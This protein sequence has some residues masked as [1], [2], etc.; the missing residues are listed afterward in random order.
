MAMALEHSGRTARE[1]SIAAGYSHA[2]VSEITLGKIR[3]LHAT[4]ALRLARVLGVRVEWLVEGEGRP[5]W[6]ESAI[7]TGGERKDIK[8]A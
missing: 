3:E 2:L 5:G 6:P 1:V 4:T 7:T 8:R